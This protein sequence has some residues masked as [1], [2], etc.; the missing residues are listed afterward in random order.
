MR[1]FWRK[2]VLGSMLG[3]LVVV[4]LHGSALA[5]PGDPD[6]SFGSGGLVTT[7]FTS[8]N[9]EAV[10][11]ARQPDGRI[12]VGGFSQP[13]GF[14]TMRFA[15][16]RYDSGGGL[17]HS[18]GGDGRVTTDFGKGAS[19]INGVAIDGEGRLVAAGCF[20]LA[21]T[22]NTKIALARYKAGGG[23]DTTFGGDGKVITNFTPGYDCA[24]D[25]VVR[26]NDRILLGGGI[27]GSGGQ[28]GLVRYRTNGL[29]DSTFS[30]DGRVATNFDTGF[31]HA[32]A[33]AIQEDGKIVLTGVAGPMT[34]NDNRFALARYNPGGG[35]D[36]S[37][38]GDGKVTTDLTDG[39]DHAWALAIQPGGEIVAV[40]AASGSGERFA[41][42]RY[43][44]S[45]NLDASFGTGGIQILN[46]DTGS[47]ALASVV[48]Q[49]DGSILTAGWTG[50]LNA[51]DYSF[52]LAR[53]ET[54]GTPDQA[55]GGDGIVTTN[56]TAGDDYA[57]DLALQPNGRAIVTG[58]AAS[59]GG[60]F[61]LVRYLST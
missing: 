56:L 44:S 3:L 53:F 59:W 1:P 25:V 14:N 48:L 2:S 50:P 37:F 24:D 7:N 21:A 9:D 6:S 26:A 45:G 33:L 28:F 46:L 58:R 35:L 18:F 17:D 39:S 30:G 11:I 34:S 42:V 38:G 13:A 12:V 10:A 55:F 61:A 40:G 36:T 20:H 29:L 47:D 31:D 54:D 22:S 49:E 16:A 41:L 52:V 51:N 43:D 19:W 32:A 4:A 5:I 8:G 57:W 23:L 60:E 15:L 27:G